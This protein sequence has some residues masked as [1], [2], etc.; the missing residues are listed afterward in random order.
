MDISHRLLLVG[1]L[2]FILGY[3][4]WNNRITFQRPIPLVC[5]NPI[6]I[7]AFNRRFVHCLPIT[8][9]ILEELANRISEDPV[10]QKKIQSEIYRLKSHESLIFEAGCN[11]STQPM[12][13][14]QLVTLGLRLELNRLSMTELRML[15]R[16]G[17]T[18][19]K[20]ILDARAARGAFTA[21]SELTT[22]EGI[23]PKTFKHLQ[24]FLSVS[25][26]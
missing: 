24:T 22:I 20:R 2:L 14:A 25:E 13:S 11:Y 6:G 15:P 8:T 1:C 21:L 18:L 26:R 9:Q 5:N 7:Q 3:Q 16:I 10:C 19:A 4:L 23:G 12:E 17:P